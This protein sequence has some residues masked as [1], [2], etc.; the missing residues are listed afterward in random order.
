MVRSLW[1]IAAEEKEDQSG[2]RPECVAASPASG[3]RQEKEAERKE[4]ERKREN[5]A[6]AAR[7]EPEYC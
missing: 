4:I 6:E 2:S 1:H 5:E 7:P 3:Y